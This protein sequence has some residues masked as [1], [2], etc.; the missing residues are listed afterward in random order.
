LLV[1]KKL[2]A[3]KERK[4]KTKNMP[5]ENLPRIKSLFFKLH[6]AVISA[7]EKNLPE[8][9]GTREQIEA[10]V[11]E[12]VWRE[13]A[14]AVA[15]FGIDYLTAYKGWTTNRPDLVRQ[16]ISPSESAKTVREASEDITR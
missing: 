1:L 10:L 11:A 5:T 12:G 15:V 6:A 14:E 2:S 3:K 16:E 7:R 4:V 13:Y 8:T 9:I